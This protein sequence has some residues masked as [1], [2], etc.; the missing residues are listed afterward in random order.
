M[1]PVTDELCK[2]RA[3]ESEIASIID[4]GSACKDSQMSIIKI[5]EIVETEYVPVL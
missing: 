2:W 3:S 4:H 5:E 1:E